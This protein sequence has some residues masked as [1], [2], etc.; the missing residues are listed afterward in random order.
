MNSTTT[1][2]RR[3]YLAGRIYSLYADLGWAVPTSVEYA[4]LADM[5]ALVA[6]AVFTLHDRT[7]PPSFRVAAEAA[8]AE[9]EARAAAAP[10]Q[11][12][13]GAFTKWVLDNGMCPGCGKVGSPIR[14]MASI[15]VQTPAQ[16]EAMRET[17]AEAT[18]RVTV[19]KARARS[20]RADRQP[21]P[22]FVADRNTPGFYSVFLSGSFVGTIVKRT[23]EYGT[24]WH[25][26][27][28][29]GVTPGPSGDTRIGTTWAMIN[30]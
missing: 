5:E 3:Q 13:C 8:R 30:S 4:S 11:C 24:D 9:R 2:S 6:A 26:M 28:A 25:T 29:D 18:A 22:T 19:S 17:F 20:L 16:A 27:H 14:S 12:E 1:P 15:P 21:Q 23:S 7:L 10:Q